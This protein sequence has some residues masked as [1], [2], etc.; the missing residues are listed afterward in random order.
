[1]WNGVLYTKKNFL[2]TMHREN[3]DIVYR[4]MKGDT[5]VTPGKI[6]KTDIKGWIAFSGAQVVVS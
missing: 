5:M 3:A 4:R 2:D 1:M 6:K